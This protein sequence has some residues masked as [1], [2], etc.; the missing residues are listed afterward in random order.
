MRKIGDCPR[1]LSRLDPFNG[2]GSIT[3]EQGNPEQSP[4]R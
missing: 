1:S 3:T 4:E 2:C